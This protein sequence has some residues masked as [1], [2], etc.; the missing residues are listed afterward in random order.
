MINAPPPSSSWSM[1]AAGRFSLDSGTDRLS[2]DLSRLS[3]EAAAR[4][5]AAPTANPY[6]SAFFMAGAP[7][8]TTAPPPSEVHAL[9]LRM[10][11]PTAG[12]GGMDRRLPP[13]PPL[14]T[15]S[16]K[17][18]S[19]GERAGLCWTTM[20][21]PAVLCLVAVP[22][23]CAGLHFHCAFLLCCAC[24]LCLRL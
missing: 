23:C 20:C 3:F 14:R 21:F 5:V 13:L 19:P 7:V 11:A 15:G 2:E 9:E 18:S 8:G 12:M 24:W 22:S 16:N 17:S 10:S 1:G 6:A 4:P